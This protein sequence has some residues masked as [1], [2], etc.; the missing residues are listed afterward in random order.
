MGCVVTYAWFCSF[1]SLAAYTPMS[2]YFGEYTAF[3]IFGAIN[4]IG[5]IFVIVFLPE[6][7]GKNDQEIRQILSKTEKGNQQDST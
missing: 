3:F 4:L 1:L 5:S 7:R 6:T 2:I